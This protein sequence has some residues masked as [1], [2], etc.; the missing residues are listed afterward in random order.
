MPKTISSCQRSTF[1]FTYF[2]FAFFWSTC[3]QK[4]KQYEKNKLILSKILCS[5]FINNRLWT[6]V[7]CAFFVYKKEKQQKRKQT[8]IMYTSTLLTSIEGI[9]R[10]ASVNDDDT[11]LRC[12]SIGG[13]SSIICTQSMYKKEYIFG[14]FYRISMSMHSQ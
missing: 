5:F 12:C 2:L 1:H 6:I 3:T 7:T 10:V 9:T 11:F 14:N 4:V 13:W 8:L